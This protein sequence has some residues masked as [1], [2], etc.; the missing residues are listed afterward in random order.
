MNNLTLTSIA[1]LLEEFCHWLSDKA[2]AQVAASDPFDNSALFRAMPL[3]ETITVSVEVL[4]LNDALFEQFLK[5]Q[6]ATKDE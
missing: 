2:N 4:R 6:E 3:L 5:E 1:E